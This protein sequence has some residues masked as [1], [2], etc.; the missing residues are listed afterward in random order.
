MT[1]TRQGISW[2]FSAVTV[3]FIGLNWLF[4]LNT[5]FDIQLIVLAVLAV[6]FALP[7]GSTDYDLMTRSGYPAGISYLVLFIIGYLF[8]ASL[9]VL[10]WY[11]SPTIFLLAFIV[12]SIYHFAGDWQESLSHYGSVVLATCVIL[13]GTLRF[14]S[15]FTFDPSS[16]VVIDRIGF[17]D[18]SNI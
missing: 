10:L 12:F 9:G 2:F 16:G 14:E 4:D 1:L 8:L 11:I 7:H 6:L 17:E 18:S 3:L 5:H 15:D 13:G